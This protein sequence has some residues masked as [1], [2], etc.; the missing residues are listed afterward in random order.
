MTVAERALLLALADAIE[1]L[2]SGLTVPV[3]VSHRIAAMAKLVRESPAAALNKP[4]GYW[5]WQD[6]SVND[7]G[8]QERLAQQT[9]TDP[10]RS[11]CS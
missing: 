3:D 9:A 6:G 5:V 4:A 7:Q 11:S 1:F 2:A 8:S 10:I